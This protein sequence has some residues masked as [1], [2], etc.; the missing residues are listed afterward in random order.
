M[1]E[2]LL[3]EGVEACKIVLVGHS[4]GSG[5][6]A[7]LAYRLSQGPES[8]MCRGLVIVAGYTSIADAGLLETH[9]QL[10]GLQRFLFCYRSMAIDLWK[11]GSKAKS[12]TSSSLI[13]R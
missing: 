3:K 5:V 6:A 12:E 2:W 1:Y 9:P 13:K 10:L 11:L 7:D 8:K 4:L